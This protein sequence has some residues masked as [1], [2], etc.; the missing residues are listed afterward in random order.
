MSAPQI[1]FKS[2]RG[3]APG[4]VAG[5][6][7]PAGRAAGAVAA[8][9]AEAFRPFPAFALCWPAYRR[10]APII[11]MTH[12]LSRH[13][14]EVRD[15]FLRAYDDAAAGHVRWADDLRRGAF[16]ARVIVSADPTF[17]LPKGARR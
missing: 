12:T 16:I 15:A 13:R 1:I 17:A 10:G 4:M 3:L 7:A 14:S 2:R 11:V 6:Q 5:P 8:A 9:P